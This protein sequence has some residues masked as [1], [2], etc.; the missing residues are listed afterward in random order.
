MITSDSSYLTVATNNLLYEAGRSGLDFSASPPWCIG[1]VWDTNP[2]F[3]VAHWLVK[4]LFAY[5]YIRSAVSSG[6]RTTLDTWFLNMGNYWEQVV[7]Q[8]TRD[9]YAT[10]N[11]TDNLSTFTLSG[12]G[13]TASNTT[14]WRIYCNGPHDNGLSGKYQNRMASFATLFGQIGVMLNDTHLKTMFKRYAMEYLQFAVFA[15][16]APGEFQRGLDDNPNF[17]AGWRYS[18]DTA[19]SLGMGIDALARIGDTDLYDYSTS[20]GAGTG[21]DSTAGGAKT[22]AL[23]YSQLAKYVNQTETGAPRYVKNDTANCSSGGTNTLIGPQL[24]TNTGQESNRDVFLA[25][26]NMYYKSISGTDNVRS[27]YMRT[28]TGASSYPASPEG[29]GYYAGG[30]PSGIFPGELFMFGQME[31]QVNPYP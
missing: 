5:D 15:D 2:F 23:I 8:Q 22:F 4:L 27:Q 9:N 26:T 11:R 24:N 31:D 28:S 10:G 14:N 29:G 20:N 18:T 12:A 21:G 7:D 1:P 3:D 13:V 17:Q 16:G 6:N 25:Q 30:G 19:C